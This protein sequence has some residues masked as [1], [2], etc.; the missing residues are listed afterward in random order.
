MKDQLDG[1]QLDHEF[2]A[3]VDGRKLSPD[4][5]E[6]M[7]D[8]KKAK[9]WQN[10]F[11]P[12]MIGCALSHYKIYRQ[13]IEQNI[14]YA[15]VL[16]DDTKLSVNT[17]AVLTAIER[18]FSAGTLSKDEP[19]LL[20]Y[21]SANPVAFTSISQVPVNKD[22]TVNHPL[23]I[24]Q[25]ITTAAYVVTYECAKRLADLV[26]PVRYPADSWGVFY[27][28]KAIHGLRCVLPLPIESGYFKSEI[29]YELN[30]PFNN[31]IKKL[32]AYNVFPIKQLLQARRRKRALRQNRYTIVTGEVNWVA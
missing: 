22:Y 2:F 32:E 1:L 13:I 8:M 30:N 24:W 9:E 16:E 18:H 25:P 17:P 6:V 4:E 27:R 5:L 28:E 14:P 31:L 21:Q 12:G 26:Y 20:Y 23:N 15:F 19:V 10:L 7:C 3:A 29:G 11:T